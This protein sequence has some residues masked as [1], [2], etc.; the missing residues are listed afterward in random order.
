[1][2]A[3]QPSSRMESRQSLSQDELQ[4]LFENMISA[5]SYYR[6]VY[7]AEG[8]P[9]DYVFLAV[10]RAFEL[11]TGKSREE[12]IGKNVKSVYPETEQYWIDFFGRV[13]KSG[14]AEHHQLLICLS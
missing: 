12:F 3:K 14:K 11:E 2:K 4:L 1:M 5:F 9:V 6:M 13:A 8:H 7:D 10:N